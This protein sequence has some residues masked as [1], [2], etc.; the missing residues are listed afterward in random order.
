M[1]AVLAAKGGPGLKVAKVLAQQRLSARRCTQVPLLRAKVVGDRRR[2][3]RRQAKPASTTA[4]SLSAAAIAADFPRRGLE[5]RPVFFCAALEKRPFLPLRSRENV[6]P[7]NPKSCS[8]RAFEQLKRV[9]KIMIYVPT[10][11]GGDNVAGDGCPCLAL[12]QYG[13]PGV[14]SQSPPGYRGHGYYNP[15]ILRASQV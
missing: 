2:H 14:I 5:K 9:L 6:C 8:L 10:R 15:V 3:H 7:K 4:V 12:G 13:T 1:G 11:R